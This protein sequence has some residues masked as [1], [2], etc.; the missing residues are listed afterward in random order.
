MTHGIVYS[1]V[2]ADGRSILVKRVKNSINLYCCIVDPLK[3][4][5]ID[6]MYTFKREG[7]ALVFAYH[8]NPYDKRTV[9]FIPP[10]EFSL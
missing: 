8:Y 9:S 2:M 5:K 1:R 7:V 4:G 3:Y 10:E 6:E